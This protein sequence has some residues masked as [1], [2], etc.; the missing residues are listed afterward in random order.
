MKDIKK[1]YN[2]KWSSILNSVDKYDN[3]DFLAFH[4]YINNSTT[5]KLSKKF[6]KVCLHIKLYTAQLSLI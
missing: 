1:E 4:A 5:K 3:D 2:E 6:V